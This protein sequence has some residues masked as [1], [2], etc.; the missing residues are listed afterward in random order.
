MTTFKDALIELDKEIAD[1]I[2]L[3]PAGAKVSVSYLRA[4]RKK[5]GHIIALA[6]RHQI[7]K[8]Q[9]AQRRSRSRWYTGVRTNV[10]TIVA[11]VCGT[12]CV[13]PDT[14]RTEKIWSGKI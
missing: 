2:A 1:I 9:R 4:L 13:L 5:L 6:E 7:A 8:Q 12:V 10:F 11:I 3:Y 14:R